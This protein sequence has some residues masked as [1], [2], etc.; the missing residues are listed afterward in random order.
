[1]TLLSLVLVSLS[2][3]AQD[4]TRF[5]VLENYLRNAQPKNFIFETTT[6]LKSLDAQRIIKWFGKISELPI[7]PLLGPQ[8]FKNDVPQNPVE[9]TPFVAD[10]DK[11]YRIIR[12][13]SYWK[14]GVR[15]R[16]HTFELL[17]A[18]KIGLS[19]FESVFLINVDDK[20]IHTPTQTFHCLPQDDDGT[21]VAECL[22]TLDD[23][24]ND[25]QLI[26]PAQLARATCTQ[27][28][29]YPKM[30][31]KTLFFEDSLD[32]APE[33]KLF[34]NELTGFKLVL[35]YASSDVVDLVVYSPEVGK[36]P[37]SHRVFVIEG[38][39]YFD[40]NPKAPPGHIYRINPTDEHIKRKP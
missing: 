23:L 11:S 27:S 26:Q 3:H 2:V 37:L 8:S 7:R 4:T 22:K 34:M 6:E 16:P 36:E 1:M 17:K 39:L 24:V 5:V 10:I 30:I 18:T 31:Q 32:D 19:E 13:T 21:R 9:E 25:T 28:K 12:Q 20:T 38:K 14:E 29:R 33:K 40:S 15:V 35:F